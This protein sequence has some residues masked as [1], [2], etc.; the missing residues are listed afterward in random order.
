MMTAALREPE[1]A[2]EAEEPESRLLV[3]ATAV[4][5]LLNVGV[6]QAPPET[7]GYAQAAAF[8]PDINQQP[9]WAQC[10]LSSEQTSPEVVLIA[11]QDVTLDYL[12]GAEQ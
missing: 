12:Q 9:V 2:A 8:R 11:H 3:V 1:N 4:P 5:P 10:T 6:R 7:P